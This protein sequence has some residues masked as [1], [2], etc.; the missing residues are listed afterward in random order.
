MKREAQPSVSFAGQHALNQYEAALREEEDLTSVS[1]R[2]YLSDVR[3]FM[4]WC[5]AQWKEERASESFTPMLVATQL[6]TRY[7]TYLQTT[8]WLPLV[9]Q[10]DYSKQ[11]V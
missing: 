7:R 3:Q 10:R 11:T 4:A 2:N 9:A 1:I 6:I 8:L 5:E